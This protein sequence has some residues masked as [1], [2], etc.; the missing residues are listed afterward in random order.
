MNFSN[1]KA[2]WMGWMNYSSGYGVVNLEYASILDKLTQGGITVSW[3]R[4]KDVHPTNWSRLTEAQKSL[5]SKEVKEARLGI[6]KTTPHL[7]W[8]NKCKVKVGY[9]MVEN[10]KI[11][12]HW[13]KEINKMDA[14]FVPSEWLIGVFK[15]SGIKRPIYR[16]KQGI[17]SKRFPYFDRPKRNVFTFGMLGFMDERKNWQMVVKAFCSEFKPEEPVRLAIKNSE[18]DMGYWISHKYNISFL[19]RSLTYDE[20]VKFYSKIDCF[21]APSRCEGSGLTPREAM[22]TGCPVIVT[23]W[24]GLTELANPEISY[25]ITPVAI[26]QIDERGNYTHP[27]MQARLDI[28]ELMYLMR[29]AYENYN[30]TREKG[31][32]ASEFIHREYN[33]DS[34]GE[35]LLNIVKEF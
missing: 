14:V 22:A 6:I 12:P 2:Q 26:D 32:K 9:T 7:F 19:D 30:E 13:V 33:W 1:L 27:G 21:L 10:T 28:Q 4:E 8:H 29:Y 16:V 35:H 34:C 20:I 5:L 11:A 24:S 31:I 18:P 25:P 3:Q 15:D 17:N 23:N